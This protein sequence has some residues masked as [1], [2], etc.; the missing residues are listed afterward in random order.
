[1]RFEGFLDLSSVRSFLLADG[2]RQYA[3]F[4]ASLTA[5]CVPSVLDVFVGRV[6]SGVAAGWDG[7]TNAREQ[8]EEPFFFM[9]RVIIFTSNIHLHSVHWSDS[10]LDSFHPLP[11]TF[12]E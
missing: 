8:R 5:L 9:L 2:C 6:V 3:R 11:H 4:V 10:V 1:L 12:V 7:S